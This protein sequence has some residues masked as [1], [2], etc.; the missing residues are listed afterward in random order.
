MLRVV[1]QCTL[2]GGPCIVSCDVRA[3]ALLV[4]QWKTADVVKVHCI[5]RA[6]CSITH[7]VQLLITLK[8]PS[9]CQQWFLLVWNAPLFRSWL[10]TLLHLL[11]SNLLSGTFLGPLQG[12]EHFLRSVQQQPFSGCPSGRELLHQQG[13]GGGGVLWHMDAGGWVGQHVGVRHWFSSCELMLYS[14]R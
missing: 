2:W 11:H 7:C 1:L 5:E 3:R 4:P 10:G 8:L 14:M 13:G 6:L 12:W 9:G